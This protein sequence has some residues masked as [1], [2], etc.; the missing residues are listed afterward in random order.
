MQSQHKP[1]F[2]LKI[3]IFVG[4]EYSIRS[5]LTTKNQ[6]IFNAVQFKTEPN[7][8]KKLMGFLIYLLK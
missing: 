6:M 2:L 1:H 5:D 8:K 7:E 3:S 4:V